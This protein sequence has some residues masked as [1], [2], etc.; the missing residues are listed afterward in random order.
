MYQAIEDLTFTYPKD[1]AQ[2]PDLIINLY[3]SKTIGANRKLGYLRVKVEFSLN[4]H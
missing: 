1:L 3:E 4:F 2:V